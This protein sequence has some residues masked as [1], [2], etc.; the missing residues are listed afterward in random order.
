MVE[1]PKSTLDVQRHC[2]RK[3]ADEGLTLQI[4]QLQVTPAI[5]GRLKCCEASF[6]SATREPE[7]FFSHSVHKVILLQL[8][9]CP[10][11]L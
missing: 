8:H 7:S 10:F 1:F 3:L 2:K 6:T 9:M 11:L 5:V 4:P